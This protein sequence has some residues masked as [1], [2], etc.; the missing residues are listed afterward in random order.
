LR[1]PDISMQPTSPKSMFVLALSILLGFL[2]G[3]GVV[4]VRN[5][6]WGRGTV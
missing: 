5:A 2:G 1:G 6:I 3:C 4:M